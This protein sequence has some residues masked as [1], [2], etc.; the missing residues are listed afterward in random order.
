LNN[1]VSSIWTTALYI[2]APVISTLIMR[3]QS[4]GSRYEQVYANLILT[5]PLFSDGKAAV[6][7]F[8]SML[9]PSTLLRLRC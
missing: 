7:H 1:L 5:N 9:H 4:Y 3:R 8:S 6:Q 2:I